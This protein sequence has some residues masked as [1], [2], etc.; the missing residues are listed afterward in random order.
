DPDPGDDPPQCEPL[1]GSN[2]R[3]CKKTAR[4]RCSDGVDRAPNRLCDESTDWKSD[5]DRERPRPEGRTAALYR[6][7][8]RGSSVR[9]GSHGV[10]FSWRRKRTPLDSPRLGRWH[11]GGRLWWLVRGRSWQLRRSV[12]FDVD[13]REPVQP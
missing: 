3:A 2:H 9:C 13:V 10:P 12:S 11:W 6:R 7:E 4:K 8:R 5:E 1:R